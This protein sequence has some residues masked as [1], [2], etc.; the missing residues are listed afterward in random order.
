MIKKK[1][2][3]VRLPQEIYDSLVNMPQPYKTKYL[4]LSEKVEYLLTYCLLASK[5]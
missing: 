3:V 4:S 2:I 5:R 1:V